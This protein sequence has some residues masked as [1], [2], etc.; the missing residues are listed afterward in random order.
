MLAGGQWTRKQALGHLIDWATTHHNW[1]ARVLSHEK[2]EAS[3]Y[4]DIQWARRQP[5]QTVRWG[6][7]AIVWITLQKYLI[8][9]IDRMPDEKWATTCQI[10]DEEAIPFS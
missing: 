4:P 7:L 10:G 5:Y 9:L 2:L 8:H 1:C 6:Q 3:E